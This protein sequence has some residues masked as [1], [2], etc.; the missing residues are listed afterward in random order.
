MAEP[1]PGRPGRTTAAAFSR[2]GA[3]NPVASSE[4]R[5]K[6]ATR[7][8]PARFDQEA[9]TSGSDAGDVQAGRERVA[10]AQYYL[11][12]DDKNNRKN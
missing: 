10:G 12:R 2:T 11:V 6:A 9:A 7:A 3:G 1:A 8:G 4:K 5:E